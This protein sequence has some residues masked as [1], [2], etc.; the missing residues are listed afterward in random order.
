MIGR[1][2]GVVVERGSDG[3]CVV[4]VQGVGY[5]VFVPLGTLGRL[6]AAPEETTLE[7]HTLVREDALMLYGFDGSADKLAFRALLGVNSVGPKLA[8]AILG[9]MNAAALAQTIARKDRKA[10][11]AVSGVGKKTAERILL[12]LEN[13][14]DL[15]PGSPVTSAPTSAPTP[16]DAATEVI[17]ALVNLGYKRAIAEGAVARVEGD[18][19]EASLEVFLRAAL[20]TLSKA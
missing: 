9:Q 15:P 17:A 13:K 3:S 20:A 5:E 7:I 12:D 8:L 4:D 19:R 10:L 14:L 11:Q 18:A 2:R 6:P 16:G 1:L